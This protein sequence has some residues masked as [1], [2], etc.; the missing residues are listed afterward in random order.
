MLMW[1][2][3]TIAIRKN[4]VDQDAFSIE[5]FKAILSKSETGTYASEYTITT[6]IIGEKAS[7]EPLPPSS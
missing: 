7:P 1:S 6:Q 2:S 4:K 3:G 5:K